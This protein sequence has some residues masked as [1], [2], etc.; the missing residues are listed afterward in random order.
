MVA[1]ITDVRYH[2]MK[3]AIDEQNYHYNEVYEFYVIKGAS[4]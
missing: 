4:P 1:I 2:S 3:S